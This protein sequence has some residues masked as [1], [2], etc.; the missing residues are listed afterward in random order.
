M[1]HDS[2]AHASPAALAAAIDWQMR[3]REPGASASE[4]ERFD[5]W[6]ASDPAH[7]CAWRRV[8]G[9]L[10]EPARQL[11][12]LYPPGTPQRQA[13]YRSLDATATAAGPRRKLLGGAAMLL[14]AAGAGLLAHRSQPLGDLWADAR[15]ATGV[16]RRIALPDGSTL[17]LNARSAADL[18]FDARQRRVRLRAGELLAQVVRDPA[19]PRPFVVATRHGEARALG[20]RYLVREDDERSLLVVL[21]HSVALQTADGQQA[22]L[23]A[24]QAAW[25]GP[26]GIEPAGR[27]LAH[28]AGFADGVLDVRDEPLGEVIE[29]LRP[30]RPGPI[31]ISPAAARL[32]VFG[33]F[34]LAKPA[35]SQRVLQVLVDTLPI[36]VTTWGPLLTLV[37]VRT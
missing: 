10:R 18:M 16:A 32:R 9:L 25:F 19:A 2:R 1:T 15:S 31:R 7:A 30:W 28:R 27:N 26:R 34:P 4:R 17:H 5:D 20:T 11:R 8:D 33:V 35:D 14:A 24:G 36:S 22:V 37:D 12:A 6:L 13:I 21:E 3:L 23:P 29:A